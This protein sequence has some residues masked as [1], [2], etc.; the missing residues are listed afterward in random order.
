[1][2]AQ[3]G[4]AYDVDSDYAA[5]ENDSQAVQAQTNPQTLGLVSQLFNLKE[6]RNSM[7][8]QDTAGWVEVG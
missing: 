2:I 3:Y 6:R 4:L 1:M 7:G 5:I 8:D